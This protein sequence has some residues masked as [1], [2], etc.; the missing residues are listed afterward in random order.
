[1]SSSS[2]SRLII[3]MGFLGRPL[4][5]RW[6]EAGDRVFGTTRK[7]ERVGELRSLGVEPVLWDVLQ[8]IEER[9]PQ[10]ETVVFCVGFDRSQD[11]T[12][13]EVYVDGLRR[14]LKCLPQPKRFLYVSSTGVY[15]DNQGEWVDETTPTNP[16]DRSAQACFDAEELVRDYG[17]SKGVD[18]VVLRMAGIYGPERMIGN[19]WLE[20]GEVIPGSPDGLVNLIHVEDAARSVDAAARATTLSDLYVVSD[21]HPVTRGEMY[22]ALADRLGYSPP[23]FDPEATKAR[24]RGNRRV[25]NTRMRKELGVVLAYPTFRDSLTDLPQSLR[26]PFES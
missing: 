7:R 18:A 15:G 9:L 5:A 2:N 26:D 11:R 21:G 23:R 12:I 22:E 3:G 10:V 1:M 16:S 6:I 14:T 24:G 20:R 13:D 4:A 19:R 8:P 25:A 17:S